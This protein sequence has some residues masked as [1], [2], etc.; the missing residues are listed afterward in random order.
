MMMKTMTML[1]LLL[2][3]MMRRR[4]RMILSMIRVA[5]L[6]AESWDRQCRQH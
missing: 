4:K 1:L 5:T 2:M 3:T 6:C